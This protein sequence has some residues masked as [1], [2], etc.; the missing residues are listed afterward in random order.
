MVMAAAGHGFLSARNPSSPSGTGPPFSSRISASCPK[1]GRVAEPGLRGTTGVGVSWNI[2]VSVCHQV[3]MMGQRPLP[4]TR[5]YH[6]QAS[7]LMGSPTEPRMR[8]VERAWRFGHDSP[9]RM[10]PRIAVGAVYMM[11]MPYFST[12]CHQRFGYGYVGAP[13]YMKVVAPMSSGPYTM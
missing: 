2:P 10:S 12:R 4:M 8:S 3:S 5:W 6:F 13:S 11:V 7:G 1:K 9:K